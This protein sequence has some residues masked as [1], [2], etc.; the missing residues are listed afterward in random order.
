MM[1][2]SVKQCSFW[3]DK[4][5]CF[6]N[7]LS[8]TEKCKTIQRSISKYENRS[9]RFVMEQNKRDFKRQYAHIYASRSVSSSYFKFFGT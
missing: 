6:G 3:K 8:S 1:E 7:D 9:N 4:A 5:E 2:D